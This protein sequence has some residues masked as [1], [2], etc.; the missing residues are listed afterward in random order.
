[1]KL[2]KIMKEGSDITLRDIERNYGK[3]V[4]NALV[5]YCS[6]KRLNVDDVVSDMSEDGNGLTPWDKFDIWARK[7]QGLDIMGNFDDTIDWTGAE[8]DDDEREEQRTRKQGKSVKKGKRF[9]QVF[10]APTDFSTMNE[11]SGSRMEE[12][13]ILDWI[14]QEMGECEWAGDMDYVDDANAFE[15]SMPGTDG[16]DVFRVSVTKV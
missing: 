2:H 1:M 7:T 4:A 13:D 5:K 15:V 16:E 3:D 9:G 14:F 12:N 8:N 11:G 10:Q 6:T